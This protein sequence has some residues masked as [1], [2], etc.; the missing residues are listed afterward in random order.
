MNDQILEFVEGMRLAGRMAAET[1]KYAGSLV[2]PGIT[3]NEIDKAV[4]QFAMDHKATPA[5]LNYLGFPKSLC[6]SI[7]HCICHGVPDE[8]VLKEGDII[9]LDTAMIL[10]GYYGDTSATFNVGQVSPSAQS[11]IEKAYH[12]MHK[13]IEQIGPGKT[14]GDIGFA[15]SKYCN[16]ND[17]HP[18][19]EI[20]GHG[21]GKV[22]HSEPFVPSFGKKGKGYKLKP[23]T[24]ITVEP[25]V[26][27]KYSNIVEFDIPGSKH[28][29]YET[30]NKCLSAQFEHT[31]LITD[32]GYEILT[33]TKDGQEVRTF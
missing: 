20:G 22:F 16:K 12:A 7:N 4:Y 17:V 25:M 8:T 32:D 5:T 15:V 10:N 24:C 18:V 2:R 3:T 13:G 1:L 26:N 33:L 31:I 21:L 19:E 9:N 29:Y 6:T 28:K 27:E 14:T 11:I 30:D 23:W